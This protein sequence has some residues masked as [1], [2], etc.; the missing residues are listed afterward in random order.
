MKH[1]FYVFKRVIK[2]YSF[3]FF[4]NKLLL[5][6][7]IFAHI[8]LFNHIFN[9]YVLIKPHSL[10][11][12]LPLFDPR[13]VSLPCDSRVFIHKEWLW[14]A[15]VEVYAASRAIRANSCFE[16]RLIHYVWLLYVKCFTAHH[17]VRLVTFNLLC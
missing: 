9:K 2:V 11:V 6:A 12:N 7:Y 17:A 3:Y 15:I 1:R 5:H 10:N 4:S 13:L 8:T 14:I 16:R